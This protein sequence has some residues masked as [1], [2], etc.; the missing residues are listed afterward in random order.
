MR[1]LYIILLLAF[2]LFAAETI[3]D[4]EKPRIMLEEISKH[5]IRIGDG[6]N[7]KVY[8]FV[9]P[10]CK[11]SKRIIKIISTNKMLHLLNSYYIFLYRLD[12]FDSEKLIQ[13][14]YQS[15]ERKTTL[16]DVM[17]DGE[18]IDL[19]DFEASAETIKIVQEISNVSRQLNIKLR[20]YMISFEKDSKY[21]VVSE[22][23]AS[24]IEE[25]EN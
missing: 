22:G 10:M 8:V 16:L 21:C 5:A 11:Y 7:K 13:Y 6:N 9:D 25:F 14:I 15:E 17:V 2:N 12:K 24:C 3:P 1:N 20:P 23:E 19:D 18:I 4:S